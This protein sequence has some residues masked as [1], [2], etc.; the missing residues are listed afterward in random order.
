MNC[1]FF[2][3]VASALC[4]VAT[5]SAEAVSPDVII[6]KVSSYI[7]SEG[8]FIL[9]KGAAYSV[10]A[11]GEQEASAAFQAYLE[12]CDLSLTPAVKGGARPAILFTV[13]PKA[14]KG[15]ADQ[16]YSLVIGKKEIRVFAKDFD[17]AFYAVQSLIQMTAAS[18]ERR[19]ACGRIDDAPRYS[20]R[21]LM[22][23]VVRHFH[24]KEFIFKQLDAMALLKMNRFHFHLTD[25]EAWRIELDSA[26]EMV[27]KAAFGESE[28][29]HAILSKKPKTF[30]DTPEG[31]VH[32]TVYDDGTLYGGYYS[33]E[34]IREI[35][36][37]AAER[38]IEVIP[39]I[40]LP[41]HNNALLHVHPEFFCDGPHAVN[42]VIC[43]GQEAPFAFFSKVLEEVMDL[44]PSRYIH[45]GGD[46]ASKANWKPCSRCAERMK[47][48]GLKDVFE[49]QSYCIRR[50]EKLVNAHGKQL[51]GWDE[52]LEGGLSENATVMS[53]R[54]TE[55]GVKALEMEH[56]VIMTPNTYYYFD[57][58]QDAPYKEP[59]AFRNF[60]P[61]KTVYDYDP[62]V[63]NPHLLGVQANLWSECIVTDSH[64]EYML[65]PRSFAVAETGWSPK[66][67][68]D[69]EKFRANAIQ[70]SRLFQEKGYSVFDLTTEVGSRPE[71]GKEIPRIS[72]SATAVMYTGEGK[73]FKVP[74]LV[75][76]YLADW[77]FKG[78]DWVSIPAS[79][80][81]IEID[82]GSEKELHYVGAEF[83]DHNAR[84]VRAPQ[85]T[86][87]SVSTD[88]VNYVPVPVPQLHLDPRR[89][90]FSILTAGGSVSAH[91]RYVRLRFNRGGDKV[92]T[93]LSE[94]VLN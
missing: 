82:L 8:S 92:R 1:K 91:A 26:P 86:E 3:A 18:P 12:T 27:R 24:G 71:A 40:E 29:Y 72:Q 7:P 67:S 20:Y 14:L 6:P 9:E 23:D 79:E 62:G 53:W 47:Q 84:R 30:A 41:G 33:K 25:N 44:F 19:L 54:G 36:A 52:I 64:F 94:V 10:R 16:A 21:G 22:F 46:E 13:G 51:V 78:K 73:S 80:V 83:M 43:V 70:L 58:G 32:G 60:L 56:D 37:Y 55:G 61:L 88:G 59:L 89:Q 65:Y 31:Y 15:A 63:D 75:D 76:G 2:L 74:A 66:G 5:A 39:E 87:F 85:D 81:T 57:Y 42:N 11:K 48:E 28:W 45:I 68:K 69:Y 34:D 35:L 49:L 38:H 90:S 93:Y 4:I 17:G 50:V 77:C